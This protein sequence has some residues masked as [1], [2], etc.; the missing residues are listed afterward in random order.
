MWKIFSRKSKRW[1]RP[2]PPSCVNS[3]HTMLL[4][5]S[6]IIAMPKAEGFISFF[7]SFQYQTAYIPCSVVPWQCPKNKTSSF[8]FISSFQYRR[9]NN[10]GFWC[11]ASSPVVLLC[12][13]VVSR[14]H[15]LAS[16]K[17]AM[18]N[19]VIRAWHGAYRLSVGCFSVATISCVCHPSLM[20]RQSM[21]FNVDHSCTYRLLFSFDAVFL[22]CNKKRHRRPAAYVN[23]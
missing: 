13:V 11:F 4:I 12:Y 22:G 1:G 8:I 2:P 9:Y 20:F 21:R 3:L 16:I 15:S 23:A 17:I 14:R 10:C 7:F 5:G 6:I 18:T 19:N